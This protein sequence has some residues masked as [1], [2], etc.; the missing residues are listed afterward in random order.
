MVDVINMETSTLA[1]L[2]KIFQDS[3]RHVLFLAVVSPTGEPCLRGAQLVQEIF[4]E[5]DSDKLY[6]AIVW[7][8]ML[9]TDDIDAAN[10]RDSQFSDPRVQQFWD[11][12]RIVGQ[13]LSQTLKLNESIAWDVYLVYL[14]DHS[15]DAK[16]PPV[17]GFWMHQL[18]EEPTL[19]LDSPRLKQYV[20]TLL[21]RTVLQ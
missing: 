8:P 1:L 7:T 12:D 18:N 4:E 20:Q 13:Y 6:G 21:E 2:K 5:N 9:E 14:P 10:E 19:L 15:W 16:L 17:T 11:Q 3:K